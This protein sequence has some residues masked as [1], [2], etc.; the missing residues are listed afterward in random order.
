M[1]DIK[2]KDNKTPEKAHTPATPVEEEKVAI[3]PSPAPPE[4]E[5]KI[6]TKSIERKLRQ[7]KVKRLILLLLGIIIFLSLTTTYLLYE[8]HV[9]K[10]FA[11]KDAVINLDI[12]SSPAQIIEAV[13]HHILLP[14]GTPQIATV[15]DA[16]K[17]N[18]AQAFFKDAVNGD[19]V[20]VY[21]T[22]IIL[23]RPSKDLL[24]AVGDISGVTSG[25]TK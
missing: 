13:S 16:K 21:D 8:V 5:E 19:V 18:T 25:A 12:A 7:K 1:L 10:K 11:S 24:I 20:L 4:K 15:Q 14:Q 2:I 6:D 23:Y 3:S 17:L 22:T 9:M